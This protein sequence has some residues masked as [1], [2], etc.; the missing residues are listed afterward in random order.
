MGRSATFALTWSNHHP[1]ARVPGVV[2]LI[3]MALTELLFYCFF[4]SIAH[5]SETPLTWIG[6]QWPWG[7]FCS[8]LAP[9]FVKF[10]NSL[11]LFWLAAGLKE[12]DIGQEQ[13]M[14]P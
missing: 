14:L 4:F 13:L 5:R 7:G 8:T 10:V 6:N 9:E 1:T 3:F 2:N 11:N 12:E